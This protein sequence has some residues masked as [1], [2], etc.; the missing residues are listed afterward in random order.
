MNIKIDNGD[1]GS[2]KKIDDV[3]EVCKYLSQTIDDNTTEVIVKKQHNAD[4]TVLPKTD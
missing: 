3:S 1:Y 2:T 4:C